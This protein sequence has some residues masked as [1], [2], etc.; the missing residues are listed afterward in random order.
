MNKRI[1]FTYMETHQHLKT[2]GEI[3]LALQGYFMCP[4]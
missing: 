2:I 1:P 3:E 4:K